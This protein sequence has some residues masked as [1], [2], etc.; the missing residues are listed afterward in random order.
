[1]GLLDLFSGESGRNAALWAAGNQQGG[2]DQQLDYINRGADLSLAA[3]GAGNVQARNDLMGG[4]GQARSD[5]GGGI[6]QATSALGGGAAQAFAALGAGN[7]QA[8]AALDTGYNQA[9][10]DLGGGLGA[11]VS[12]LNLNP[13]VYQSYGAQADSYYAP[14]AAGADRGYSA[15]GDAAGANGSEGQARARQ[16]FQTGP[17]YTFARDEATNAAARAANATGMGASGNTLDAVTRLGNNL[18]NQE[19]GSYVNRLSPYLSLAPQIA[20]QRAG[21][22]QRTGELIGQNTK[23]T[24]GL[25]SGYGKDLAGLSSGYGGALANL[26]AGYG[27]DMAGIASGYGRELS[28]LSSGYG[29]AMAGLSSGAGNTLAS[30]SSGL[31]TNMAGIYGDQA[32]NLAN[33]TGA[34]TAAQTQIGGAG[35]QAGQAANANTWNA[36]MQVAN[37]LADT[38]GKFKNPFG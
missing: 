25:Y 16:N 12:T 33:I 28:G 29:T 22:S 8:G 34:N 37:L 23:D 11:A 5:L 3:L 7:N 2:A 13:A 17:G 31:G 6:N 21:I 36:G 4:V 1:M 27:R 18:A 15:Y 38:A 19:W 9:R 30:L 35:F 24:A 10:S 26:S 14:L 20:G 32:R